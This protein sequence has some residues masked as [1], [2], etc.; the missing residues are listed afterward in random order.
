MNC[1]ET[2]AFLEDDG[3]LDGAAAEHLRQCAACA[4]YAGQVKRENAALQAALSVP[5]DDAAWRRV[6]AGVAARRSASAARE[7]RLT[8]LCAGL[9]AAIALAVGLGLIHGMQRQDGLASGDGLAAQVLRLQEDVRSQ[10]VLDEIVQLQVAFAGAGDAEAQSAAEDAELYLERIL[11]LDARRTD[12]SHEIL[13]GIKAAGIHDCLRRM[14]DSLH[15]DAPEP[16]TKSLDLAA[17]AL[18]EAARLADAGGI[19]R[20]Q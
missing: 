4:E 7:R 12:Q 19:G 2:R 3:P 18:G 5:P 1:E 6:N 10:Q 13:A 15:A 11:S 16:V 14:K 20:V 9:A 17:R 8:W